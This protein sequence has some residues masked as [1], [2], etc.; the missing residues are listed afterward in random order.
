MNFNL[1]AALEKFAVIAEVM[2]ESTA[3]LSLNDAA[4]MAV[5]AVE[6]LID[7]CCIFDSLETLEIE[8]E[9]FPKLAKAAMTVAR[10]LANNPRKVTEEDAIEI[11]ND[12]Y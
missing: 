10:P 7:D 2:G 1:P 3:D 4:G 6:D 11:Y 8:E 9:D 12:A 5:A